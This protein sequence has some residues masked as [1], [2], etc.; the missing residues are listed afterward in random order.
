MGWLDDGP[1][2]SLRNDI[3][4]VG[5]MKCNI[6]LAMFLTSKWNVSDIIESKVCGHMALLC[7]VKDNTLIGRNSGKFLSLSKKDSVLW[8]RPGVYISNQA[9]NKHVTKSKTAR[10]HYVGEGKNL[11]GRLA[12][13]TNRKIIFEENAEITVIFKSKG[14]VNDDYLFVHEVRTTCERFISD[15]IEDKLEPAKCNNK[16]S[17]CMVHKKGRKQ[18]DQIQKFVEQLIKD[19]HV[20]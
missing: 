12:N 3:I 2:Q 5:G 15:S 6:S 1:N 7:K 9:N 19:K 14:I 11:A 17:W 4:E 10:S 16:P 18:I 13:R 20:S 8:S